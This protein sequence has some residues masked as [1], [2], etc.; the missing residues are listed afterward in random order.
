MMYYGIVIH[1]F[2]M[3]HGYSCTLGLYHPIS[4][5]ISLESQ[6]VLYNVVQLMTNIASQLFNDCQPGI[7]LLSCW[8]QLKTPVNIPLATEKEKNC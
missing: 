3:M 8:N 6:L 1:T 4:N 5:D 7:Y 2:G